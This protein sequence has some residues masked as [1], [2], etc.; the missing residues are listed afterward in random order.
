MIG[1]EPN[2]NFDRPDPQALS[3]VDELGAEQKSWFAHAFGKAT[4]QRPVDQDRPL[5]IAG[6]HAQDHAP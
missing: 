3:H 6:S 1:A 5:R 4:E 2:R